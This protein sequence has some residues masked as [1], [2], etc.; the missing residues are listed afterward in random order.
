M[1]LSNDLR[2][3]IRLLNTKNVKYVIVGAWAL[4]FHGRGEH[5]NAVLVIEGAHALAASAIGEAVT[6]CKVSALPRRLPTG[7][8]KTSR[9]EPDLRPSWTLLEPH[10]SSPL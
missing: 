8:E 9:S 3:F 6:R 7:G 10:F 1:P 4:A 5:H 2:D